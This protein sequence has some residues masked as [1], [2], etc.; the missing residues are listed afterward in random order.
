[1]WNYVAEADNCFTDDQFQAFCEE[2]LNSCGAG[3][4]QGDGSLQAYIVVL[5]ENITM[6]EAQAP[7]N[8]RGESEWSSGLCSAVLKASVMQWILILIW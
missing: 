7:M 8:N 5:H 4:L 2:P 6:N 3:S 1:M